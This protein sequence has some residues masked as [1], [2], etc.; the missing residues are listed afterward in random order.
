MKTILHDMNILCE[1]NQKLQHSQNDKQEIRNLEN[2][3][4]KLS[5]EVKKLK[6]GD[7]RVDEQIE[8]FLT[9]SQIDGS[10]KEI[11]QTH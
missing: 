1:E 5:E 8:F 4:E 9:V 3:N 11:L 10:V 6:A 2:I 7:V